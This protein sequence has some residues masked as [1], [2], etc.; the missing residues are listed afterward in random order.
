[1]KRVRY[2]ITS[3]CPLFMVRK[4][5]S[6]KLKPVHFKEDL[7]LNVVHD[8]KIF[9]VRETVSLS[10]LLEQRFYCFLFAITEMKTYSLLTTSVTALVVFTF[11]YL[12]YTVWNIAIIVDFEFFCGKYPFWDP[13]AQKNWFLQNVYRDLRE[14][15]CGWMFVYIIRLYIIRHNYNYIIRL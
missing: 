4:E 15:V 11:H 10:A 6:N 13:W 3:T 12:P 5:E 8:F 2:D 1:M 9:S 14:W 7:W